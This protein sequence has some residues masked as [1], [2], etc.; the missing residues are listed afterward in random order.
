MNIFYLDSNP[1]IAAKYHIDRHVI[2]MLIEYGQILSTCHRVL[3]GKFVMFT[4]PDTNKI[5]K[6]LKLDNEIIENGIVVNKLCC[7]HSHINHPS[8]KWVRLSKQ[9][10]LWLYSLWEELHKEF[11]YRYLGKDKSHKTFREY[12]EFL[13]TP[14]NNISDDCFTEPLL[15]MPEHYQ[16]DNN[17]VLSYRNYYIGDKIKMSSWKNREKPEWFKE[18]DNE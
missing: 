8:N 18:N 1:E 15:A 11:L 3:D 16:I 12:S 14:P 7:S 9:N 2:K 10:Y 6:F 4:N 5:K 17:A 13:K